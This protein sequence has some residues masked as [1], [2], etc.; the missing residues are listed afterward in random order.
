MNSPILRYATPSDLRA[1]AS[2]WQLCFGDDEGFVSR[3][4]EVSQTLEA[5]IV[6]ELNGQAAAFIVTFDN[7][8]RSGTKYSYLYALAVHPECQRQGIG[9]AVLRH[10]ISE[11]NQRGSDGAF[12][13]PAN[14][15]L[16]LRYVNQFGGIPSAYL[17]EQIF[18]ASKFQGSC[19]DISEITAADYLS[20]ASDKVHMPQ[21]L[22]AAQ[23]LLCQVFGEKFLSLAPDSCVHLAQDSNGF[24]VKNAQ[25]SRF[26]PSQLC[27]FLGTDKL[28][29]KSIS[30]K[31]EGSLHPAI[32][33]FPAKASSQILQMQAA[34]FFWL[35]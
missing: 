15:E 35:D 8:R 18:T 34:P 27:A 25:C 11:A 1:I 26:C 7:V 5:T 17:H 9:A 19:A 20:C 24:V 10:A 30:P 31:A 16:A 28:T 2:I 13:R 3:F 32:I 14:A 6:A 23:A 12:L 21:G 4:F 33:L 22:I 29:A